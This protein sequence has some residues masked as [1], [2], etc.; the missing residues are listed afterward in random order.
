MSRVTGAVLLIAG[1]AF[2]FALGSRPTAHTWAASTLN[3]QPAQGPEPVLIRPKPPAQPPDFQ[4]DTD[5]LKSRSW[6]NAAQATKDA[7]E[8]AALAKKIQ[9]EVDQLSKNVL[10]SDLDR[11]LKHVQRLAKRLRGEITP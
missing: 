2:G 4:D 11:D 7:K 3:P 9:G 5:G 8:L 1:M 6:V 10:P